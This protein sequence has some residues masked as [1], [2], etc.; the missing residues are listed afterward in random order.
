[1]SAMRSWNRDPSLAP[2]TLTA[3]ELPN[4][5]LIWCQARIT[6]RLPDALSLRGRSTLVAHPRKAVPPLLRS[7]PRT[8][9]V[10]ALKEVFALLR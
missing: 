3:V 7:V 9:G 8:V 1:M 6:S 10:S 2:Q 4:L 5:N